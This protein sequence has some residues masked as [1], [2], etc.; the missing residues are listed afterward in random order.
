MALGKAGNPSAVALNGSS[1][2]V[3]WAA[4]EEAATYKIY[5]SLTT[6]GGYSEVAQVAECEYIDRNLAT[7]TAYYYKI[8]SIGAD[9][10]LGQYSGAGGATTL[11]GIEQGWITKEIMDSLANVIRAKTNTIDTLFPVEMAALV[12]G[13]KGNFYTG[14]FAG[15]GS[16]NTLSLGVAL[17]Q[18]EKYCFMLVNYNG[19]TY[20]AGIQLMHGNIAVNYAYS[21]S[22]AYTA[23]W[24]INFEKGTIFQQNFFYSAGNRY[25]WAYFELGD[26]L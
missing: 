2:H 8:R 25:I 26:T 21:G 18:F 6:E 9:G 11:G 10:T 20:S 19:G 14:T 24:T 17:P 15:T 13:I 5:R 7:N 4:A 1:I 23:P 22:Q 12:E 3:K 16:H